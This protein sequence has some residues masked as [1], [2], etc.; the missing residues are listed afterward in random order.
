MAWCSTINP[1]YAPVVHAHNIRQAAQIV[2]LRKAPAAAAAA[3]GSTAAAAAAAAAHGSAQSSGIC[4]GERAVC[5]FRF[6][7]HPEY[8]RVGTAIVLREGQTRGFGRVL[9]VT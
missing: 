1:R 7:H 9:A 6:M 8:L 2:S 4:S 3:T 5:R